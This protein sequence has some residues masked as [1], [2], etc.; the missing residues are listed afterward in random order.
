MSAA[1][2]YR[3]P[4]FTILNDHEF[5]LVQPFPYTWQDEKTREWWRITIPAGYPFD[6]A[7]V[8][9]I[10]WTLTNLLPTGTHLGAAA[11]HDYGYQ[12]RGRLLRGEVC[13]KKPDW[14]FAANEEDRWMPLAVAWQDRKI[15]DDLFRRI[16]RDAGETAWKREAMY[17]AVRLFGGP[18]WNR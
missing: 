2:I 14:E 8:P 18:A 15:W 9:R 5:E 7:S 1:A 6:G 12:R 13:I 4:V 3:P 11:V 17:R 10:C 16:M